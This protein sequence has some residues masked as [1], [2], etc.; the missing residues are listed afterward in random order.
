[1]T[2]QWFSPQ[3]IQAATI[4]AQPI[5]QNSSTSVAGAVLRA[6]GPSVVEITTGG[7]A[8]YDRPK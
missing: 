3:T 6:V 4:D 2:A 7:Q 5:A 1:V 8:G